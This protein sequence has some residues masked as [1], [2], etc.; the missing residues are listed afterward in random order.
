VSWPDATPH[1]ARK[2]SP[3]IGNRTFAALAAIV[4]NRHGRGGRGDAGPIDLSDAHIYWQRS[5]QLR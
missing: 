5:V 3:T 1:S 2:T 4:T